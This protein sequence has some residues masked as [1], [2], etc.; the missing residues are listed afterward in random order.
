M[1]LHPQI[2]SCTKTGFY[3]ACHLDADKQADKKKKMTAAGSKSP[4]LFIFVPYSGL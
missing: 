1:F 3:A 2:L 4:T